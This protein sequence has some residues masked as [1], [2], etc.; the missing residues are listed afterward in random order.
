MSNPKDETMNKPNTPAQPAESEHVSTTSHARARVCAHSPETPFGMMRT[1][2]SFQQLQ[3]V[4]AKLGQPL[5]CAR[6]GHTFPPDA[7]TDAHECHPQGITATLGAIQPL[8]APASL[9]FYTDYA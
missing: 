6:C 8:A 1:S 7:L 4:M 5:S 3:V 9:V 2:L